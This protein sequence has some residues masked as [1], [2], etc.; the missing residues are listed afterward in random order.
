MI[1]TLENSSCEGRL[2]KC[3]SAW[4]CLEEEEK[5]RFNSLAEEKI[6]FSK[7]KFL[8]KIGTFKLVA[9]LLR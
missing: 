8:S 2:G 1:A 4:S 7:L 9:L 3:A 6:D 5:K